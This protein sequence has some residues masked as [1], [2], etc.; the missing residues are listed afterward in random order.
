L[1]YRIAVNFCNT[2]LIQGFRGFVARLGEVAVQVS[3][4]YMSVADEAYAKC[5]LVAKDSPHVMG[6]V[7][8]GKVI[9]VGV[10]ANGFREGDRVVAFTI[11]GGGAQSILTVGADNAIAYNA[12]EYDYLDSLII[13]VLSVR[14]EL[15]E[16]VKGANVLVVGKDLS[17]IPFTYVAQQHSLKVFTIPKY[18]LWPDVVKGEHISVYEDKRLFDVVVMASCD[19]LIVSLVPRLVRDGA[20]LIVHPATRSLLR[21]AYFNVQSITVKLMQF[22]DMASGEAVHSRFKDLI[23]SRIPVLK[24]QDFTSKPVFPAITDLQSL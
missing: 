7:A 16:L 2:P 11:T 12:R 13:A 3:Y 1:Y 6:T 5:L 21:L 17:V 10:G 8:V 9:A 24:P 23:K 4:A 14:R 18:T 20:T 15:L 19:P 22:G